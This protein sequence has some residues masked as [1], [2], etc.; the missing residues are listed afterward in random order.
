[1]KKRLLTATA[2]VMAVVALGAC[3]PEFQIEQVFGSAAPAATRVAKCESGL[4]PNAVSP[5]GGNHGLFQINNVHKS[6]FTRVT[7]AS[8]SKIYDPYLNTVYAKYL[9]DRQGWRPWSCK[10]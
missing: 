4:N 3:S 1:M 2:A 5:G 6:E 10:P 8:W 7:G 9:Y